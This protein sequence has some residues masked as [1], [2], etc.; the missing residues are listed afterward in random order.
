MKTFFY[1]IVTSLISTGAF[2][3]GLNQPNPLPGYGIGFVVW[4]LFFWGWHRRAKKAE[5]RRMGER[6]F[7]NYMRSKAWQR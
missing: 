3:A 7:E 6:L 1:L 2:F 4:A 5:A